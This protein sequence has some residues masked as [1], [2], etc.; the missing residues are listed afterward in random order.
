MNDEQKNNC[1]VS[2]SKMEDEKD[3]PTHESENIDDQKPLDEDEILKIEDE[4]QSQ[5]ADLNKENIIISIL[6]SFKER[7]DLISKNDFFQHRLSVFVKGCEE[8]ESDPQL[9]RDN[10]G[11]DFVNM[12]TKPQ[13]RLKAWINWAQSQGLTLGGGL[14]SFSTLS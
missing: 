8:K 9:D 13:G 1:F 10:I 14:V 5:E 11:H 12:T 4:V 6:K 7:E 2:V 3:V